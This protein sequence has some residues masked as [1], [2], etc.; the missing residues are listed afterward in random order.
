ML[1]DVGS[2][3]AARTASFRLARAGFVGTAIAFGPARMGF[4]L[5]LP[6]FRDDFALSPFHAGLIAGGGF[7]AFLAALLVAAWL[8]I[9]SGPRMAVLAGALSALSGFTLVAL[10]GGPGLLAVGIALAGAS[11]GLCW[12]PFN[13]AAGRVV[14]PAARSQTL[15]VIA[16]GTTFG[17]AA[18]GGLALGV[19]WG[20]ADWRLA[21]ALFALA[22]LLAIFT[23]V[24]GLPAGRCQAPRMPLSPAMFRGAGVCPLY[25]SAFVFGLANAAYLSFAA[26]SVVSAGGLAGLP[27]KAAP[28]VIFISY[29]AFGLAGLA[30]ARIEARLGTRAVL[31]GVFC[32]FAVSLGLVAATPGSWPG[33][34]LSAGL[35]GAAVMVISALLSVWSLRLFP[36]AGAIGM[37]AALVMLAI[38]SVLGALLAGSLIDLAGRR[39]AFLLLA[40]PPA[41]AALLA[42]SS[43]LRRAG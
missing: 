17:V 9:R 25:A 13:D 26:D 8:C 1:K 6:A 15:S 38:G 23:A 32:A 18:A 42:A 21:W 33:I 16:T 29:G 31:A 36:E 37:T 19:F 10:A 5:F 7:S 22:G 2:Q 12:S 27:D 4:G 39:L 14:P 28:S 40:A 24:T 20:L 11:A 43:G 35:H 3:D 41:I 34:V 30:T